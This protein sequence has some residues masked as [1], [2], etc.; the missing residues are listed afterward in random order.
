[1]RSSVRKD[2]GYSFPIPHSMERIVYPI[3][4][5][6]DNDSIARRLN[7]HYHYIEHG[8]SYHTLQE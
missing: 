4:F 1:M 3:P 8:S 7:Y 2:T 5:R 6:N